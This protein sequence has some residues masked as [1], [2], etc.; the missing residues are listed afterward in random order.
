V[1]V[2]SHHVLRMEDTC[3]WSR[4]TCWGWRIRARGLA[5]R[6]EDDIHVHVV[7]HHVLMMTYTC[8]WSRIT[9]WWWHTRA[10]G[11]QSRAENGGHVHVHVDQL[12]RPRASSDPDQPHC[13]RGALVPSRSTPTRAQMY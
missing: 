7:S 6:A 8:T 9:C 2:V 3:T 10:R 4:I 5:S 1:H 11:T 12:H 13:W